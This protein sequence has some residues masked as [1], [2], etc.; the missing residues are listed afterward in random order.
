M[1]AEFAKCKDS[2]ATLKANPADPAANLAVGR[3]FSF[4][5][6]RPDIGIS[7]LARGSDATLKSLATQDMAS[8]KASAA[9]NSLA[10]G[11]A[12]LAKAVPRGIVKDAMLGRA[13][14]WYDA[15]IAQSEGL[16]KL[17][18]QKR[19]FES[20]TDV[21]KRGL[22]GEYF[23]GDR[24]LQKA[25]S[26]V[27]P[28][29]DFNWNGQVPDADLQLNKFTIRWTGYIKAGAAGAYQ[30]V[31]VHD[32]GIKVWLDG[33]QIVDKWGEVGKDVIPVRL[34]GG[35]QSLKIE[36]RQ[37]GGGSNMGVGWILPGGKKG[38]AVPAEALFHDAPDPEP[39]VINPSPQSDG[40]I[41]LSPFSAEIHEPGS[42]IYHV[43]RDEIPA[44]GNWSG[45]TTCG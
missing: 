34:S 35:Y 3:F 18:L 31:F 38:R 29:I 33:A 20:R 8:P 37:E 12:A 14:H 27:D 6:D 23:R 4:A 19:A 13:A 45:Q 10:E 15:A 11:W 17:S 30:L 9:Q 28:T 2:F 21:L 42:I 26:Q 24:F 41:S 44:L 1:A 43:K 25:Y 22:F 40:T 36:Y 16:A 5:I 39:I 7:M 32:D